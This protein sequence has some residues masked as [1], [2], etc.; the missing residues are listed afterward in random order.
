MICTPITSLPWL[1]GSLKKPV[2][3]RWT[4]RE[5]LLYSTKRGLFDFEYKD[6]VMKDGRIVARQIREWHDTGA[7]T[8]MSP[9]AT[10]KCGMFGSGPYWVPNI[11]V[12]AKTIFTNKPISS[13]MRGFSVINGQMPCEMQMSK[14][15]DAL[16]MD[17]WELRM[18]N[19]WRDGDLGASRYVV[20]GAG[21]IE[22][23]KKVAEMAG[24]QLPEK[25][26]AMSSR[27]R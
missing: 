5:D 4:R 10:E 25:L 1:P 11:R 24:I 12:E 18:I 6:G 23:M 14:I 8:G 16:G 15:A 21:A 20:Q 7:Y 19:A 9:Y 17:P 2:K 13:S 3:F 26:M 27:R 22:A